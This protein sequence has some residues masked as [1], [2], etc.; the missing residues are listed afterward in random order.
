M[1]PHFARRLV[2]PHA[3]LADH[4]PRWEIDG[5]S[6]L[7]KGG[8]RR[9]G[10]AWPHNATGESETCECGVSLAGC[11]PE[12]VQCHLLGAR[13]ATNLRRVQQHLLVAENCSE[14]RRVIE[15]LVLPEDKCLEVGCG[16]GVTT[17]FLAEHSMS[18]VGVDLSSKVWPA[19]P[20][21]ALSPYPFLLLSLP[22]PLSSSFSRTHCSLGPLPSYDA[23]PLPAFLLPCA[24]S[25]SGS[26][27][28]PVQIKM[29][30]SQVHHPPKPDHAAS[31]AFLQPTLLLLLLLLLLTANSLRFNSL[32]N[33][34][35]IAA[36]D[37]NGQITFSHHFQPCVSSP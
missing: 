19:A 6:R 10:G 17:S 12:D 3:C 34:M 20:T 26:G 24:R 31:L 2:S 36:G 7:K 13:H 33:S 22:L 5:Q 1:E 9:E 16:R 21:S 14:Y 37:R 15:A 29:S 27:A 8:R 30:C 18:A 35:P 4:R 11:S 25:G 23:I 28:S 32:L